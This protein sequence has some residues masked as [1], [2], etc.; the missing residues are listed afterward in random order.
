MEY[1]RRERRPEGR[2]VWEVML[3]PFF[4]VPELPE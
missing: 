4:E 2:E 1:M 3:E